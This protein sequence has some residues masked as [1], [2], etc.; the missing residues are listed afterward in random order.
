MVGDNAGSSTLLWEGSVPLAYILTD[1]LW[2]P[3]MIETVEYPVLLS[4]YV[5]PR[6]ESKPPVKC[7]QTIIADRQSTYFIHTF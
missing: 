6:L 3:V 5:S 1:V 7:L 2:S 4:T